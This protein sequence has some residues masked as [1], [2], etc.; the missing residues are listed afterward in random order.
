MRS[1]PA[2]GAATQG[3]GRAERFPYMINGE[4]LPRVRLLT[5]LL[6][7]GLLVSSITAIPLHR[8]VRALAQLTQ[9]RDQ[10]GKG[11]AP[12][13]AEW[14]M[15]VET[16]L[17]RVSVSDPFLFYGTDWLA[18][19]HVAIALA[20]LGA[21]RDPVQNRWVFLFGMRVCI[22]LIPYALIFG[23]IRG[24]PLWWRLIDCSFA[25][26]GFVPACLC[27]KMLR[28]LTN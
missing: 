24:I 9:A 27:W 8:E 20:F 21:L 18:F 10:S 5:G 15:R 28:R 2:S 23:A 7:L 13:W 4:L 11:P 1:A 22:L 26:A 16:A 17:D 25:V 12:A 14:L 3:F 6:I 19:G